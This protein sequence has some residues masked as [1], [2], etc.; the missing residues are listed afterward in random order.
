MHHVARA[1]QV[2]IARASYL[3][4]IFAY[5]FCEHLFDGNVNVKIFHVDPRIVSC[6]AVVSRRSK[7]LAPIFHRN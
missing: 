6:Y 4:E 1:P 2:R 5:K 3:A 7:S